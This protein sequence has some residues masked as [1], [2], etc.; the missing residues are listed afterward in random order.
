VVVAPDGVSPT[1]IF[2]N[3]T[4]YDDRANGRVD[5]AE[6]PTASVASN[7]ATSFRASGPPRFAP[8]AAGDRQGLTAWNG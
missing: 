8:S 2:P 6:W 4:G 7:A 3:G 5:Y 1:V